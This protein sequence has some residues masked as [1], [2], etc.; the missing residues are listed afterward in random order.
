MAKRYGATEELI[1]SLG[2]PAACPLPER[3]KQAL[4]FAETMTLDHGSLR[5][6][7][8][9]AL[10]ESWSP[11]EV[12]EIA[13]VVGIFNYLNRF[14]EGFGL[15]PTKPGEGGPEDVEGARE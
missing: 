10:Q 8:I 11:A 13:C 14:A 12:V 6:E 5:R 7:D 2:D 15:E 4:R 3:E 9:E 1:E